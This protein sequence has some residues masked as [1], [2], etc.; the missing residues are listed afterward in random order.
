[1]SNESEW[2]NEKFW[3]EVERKGLYP[4]EKTT[5]IQGANSLIE[6]ED[7]KGKKILDCGCGSG[8]FGKLLQNKGAQVIGTD[9][10]ETLLKEASKY[11]EVKRA[12]VYDLPFNDESFDFVISFMFIHVLEEP[13][14]ALQ[15]MFRVLKPKG[16]LFLGIVHPRAEKWDEKKGQCY[17]DFSTYESTERRVWVFNL[18]NGSKFTKHYIHR[19]LIFYESIISKLFTISKKL[20]PK[21]PDKLTGSGKYAKTEYLFMKLIKK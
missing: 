11:I 21:F 14:K 3:I 5:K 15:E 9:I 1:M 2:E 8:W 18:K 10:S 7:F 20:E 6:D 19:P 16:K 12:S 13:M 17:E 4:P